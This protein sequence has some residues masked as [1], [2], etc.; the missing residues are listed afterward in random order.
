MAT[1]IPAYRQAQTEIKRFI[2]ARHLRR[3]DAL[4]PESTL[5]SELGISRP[6]LREGLKALESLGIIES[7]HGEGVFVSAFSFDTII[8]NLPY[9]RLADGSSIADLLQVRAAIEVGLIMEV[10]DHID[11]KD[12]EALRVLGERMVEK[13]SRNVRFDEEDGEFHATLFRCLNNEFLNQLLGLFWQVLRRLN[14]ANFEMDK[15]PLKDSAREH[16]LIV[17]MIE[18]GN[19]VGLLEAHKK[20]FHA[21]FDRLEVAKTVL[22]P[23][24]VGTD[25]KDIEPLTGLNLQG[26]L[27]RL[28]T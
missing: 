9:A 21:A 18:A 26:R 10:V 22:S 27:D 12:V 14:E 2:E 25:R 16:L 3:G 7:R 24:A 28:I 23:T 6:S 5:A 19:K 4:P 11:Q 1:R 15:W 8:E 17:E 13:A 20:H